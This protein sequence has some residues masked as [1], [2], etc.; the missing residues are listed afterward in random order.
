MQESTAK[1]DCSIFQK[2]ER[3]IRD[4]TDKINMAKG[5]Q[6]KTMYSMELQEEA[7]VLLSCQDYDIERMDCESCHL[8][9]GLRSKTAS[10]ILKT[11]KL[12]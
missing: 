9:A 3:V 10:L 4:I 12:K 7:N 5:I 6:K 11:E 1:I 8:I 2:Q